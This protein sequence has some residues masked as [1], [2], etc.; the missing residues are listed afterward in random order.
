MIVRKN[1]I[2]IIAVF[3]VALLPR[4]AMILAWHES[5]RGHALSGDSHSYYE[6]AQSLA[7]GKGFQLGGQPTL[8][9]TPVYPL[10]VAAALK[11]GLFPIG[12]QVAQAILGALSGVII[13]LIG[14]SWFDERVG[15]LAAGIF[16]VDYFLTKQVVYILAEV[17]FI[18]FL[19]VSF[20]FLFKAVKNGKIAFYFLGG[21]FAGIATLTKEVSSF[22]FL[23]VPAVFFLDK[24][25]RKEFL[26]KTIFFVAA[27][28]IIILP[29]IAR[30]CL[31]SKDLV[32][33]TVGSGHTFYLG[34]NPQ[35]IVRMHGGDWIIERDTELP[36]GDPDMPPLYSREADRYLMKKGVEYVSAHPLHFIKLMGVK[37]LRLWFPYYSKAE[38]VSKCIMLLSY[39]TIMGFGILGI[40]LSRKRWLEFF[41]FYLF[42][43]Y[44]S[45]IH[46]I[47]IPTIRYRYPAMPFFMIFSAYAMMALWE[48][49]RA[50]SKLST[51]SS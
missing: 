37:F 14:R 22:Y 48:R 47:T 28:L 45:L 2:L 24:N 6:I 35:V 19:L 20:Y 43:A 1:W 49:F 30:N 15:F 34:N 36:K 50:A 32:F 12:V 31:I 17:V 51:V 9:R 26:K 44:L 10:F 27:F 21:L 25:G 3:S 38:P 40:I 13:F 29:W 42:L 7:E 5:G 39:S 41:P 23:A 46:T 11:L 18:F 8:R 16:S 33:L 4:I